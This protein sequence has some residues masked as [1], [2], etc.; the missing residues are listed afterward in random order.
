M[1]NVI[2]CDV[3]RAEISVFEDYY[4]FELKNEINQVHHPQDLCKKCMTR[5]KAEIEKEVENEHTD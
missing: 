1:S 3:C 2:K 5:I 4:R